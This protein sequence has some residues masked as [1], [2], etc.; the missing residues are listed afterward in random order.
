MN[1][2]VVLAMHGTPPKDFPRDEMM[3]LF[4]L[5]HRLESAGESEKAVLKKRHSELEKKMRN[6]PRTAENDPFFASSQQIANELGQALGME[7]FL[8]FNEF[9]APSIEEALSQAAAR[10]PSKIVV[11]TSMMTGG[12]T[13]SEVDIPNAIRRAQESYPGIEIVYAWPYKISEIAGF[14]AQH[15]ERFI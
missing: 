15:L 12:G 5:H 10:A 2:S 13:H 11:V 9:C 6:W 1:I 8:G 4:A 7:V 14:L 3:E